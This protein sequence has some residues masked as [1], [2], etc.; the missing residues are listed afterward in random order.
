MW[1][2]YKISIEAYIMPARKVIANSLTLRDGTEKCKRKPK[3][4]CLIV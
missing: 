3:L 4:Y 2:R 1:K